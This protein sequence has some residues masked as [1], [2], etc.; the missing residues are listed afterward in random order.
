MNTP[1]ANPLGWGF[2]A[3]LKVSKRK[4]LPNH[5]HIVPPATADIKTYS[6]NPLRSQKDLSWTSA[7]W[8]PVS[9]IDPHSQVSMKHKM[10]WKV[11]FSSSLSASSLLHSE[12]SLERN[13]PEKVNDWAIWKPTSPCSGWPECFGRY[14]KNW[15]L[16]S[17][18]ERLK[19]E[20][21]SAFIQ[22]FSLQTWTKSRINK[23]MVVIWSDQ[24][25]YCLN[26]HVCTDYSL[27]CP[28]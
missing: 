4:I 20:E 27:F 1:K 28:L 9:S 12:H 17:Y 18:F 3:H 24:L 10:G 21:L 15:S 14:H 7:S 22:L 25:W 16:N 5:C 2:A 26:P 11:F 6:P 19:N 8:S 23:I 13:I